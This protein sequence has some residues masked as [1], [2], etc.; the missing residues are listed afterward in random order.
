ML[1]DASLELSHSQR[2]VR[3][4]QKRLNLD[5]SDYKTLYN[6]ARIYQTTGNPMEATQLLTRLQTLLRGLLQRNPKDTR[7][8]S[9]LALTLT[10]LGLFPEANTLAERALELEK[11]NAGLYFMIARMYS[12][13]MY[14][15][16]TKSYDE[17]K[18]SEA[19]RILKKALGLAYRYD[20]LADADFF[21]M[22]EH[23][24][25]HTATLSPTLRR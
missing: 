10:R 1:M 20:E 7:V 2:V 19:M 25:L 6:L 14:S 12:L 24:D 17:K 21:N 15:S 22:Y 8:M 3:A 16:L 23:G 13:Q 5:S 4:C 11:S 18:R 9:Y